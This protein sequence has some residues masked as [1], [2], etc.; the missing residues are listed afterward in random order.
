MAMMVMMMMMMMNLRY[1]CR[2]L[3]EGLVGWLRLLTY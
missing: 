2:G 1:A 3:E